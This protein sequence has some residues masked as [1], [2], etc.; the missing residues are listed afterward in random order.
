MTGKGETKIL[1]EKPIPKP[2]FSSHTW[3]ALRLN[4]VLYT[5]TISIT[6]KQSNTRT[7]SIMKSVTN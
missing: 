5:C 3:I 7:A 4:T 1:K 2:H 6:T